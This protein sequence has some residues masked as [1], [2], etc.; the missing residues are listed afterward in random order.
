MPVCCCLSC[1][2]RPTQ[3]ACVASV[4]AGSCCVLPHD[5]LSAPTVTVRHPASTL[6]VPTAA[7]HCAGSHLS[8]PA[9]GALQECARL[10]AAPPPACK[11][12]SACKPA[13]AALQ[14]VPYKIVR[15]D[16][17]DAWV[18]AGGNRYSPSQVR[19]AAGAR[20]GR[21]P[22]RVG[23]EAW[24][25][26]WV[27]AQPGCVFGGAR[28]RFLNRKPLLDTTQCS[29]TTFL[30]LP[31]HPQMGAFVLMKMKETAERYLGRPVSQVGARIHVAAHCM[32]PQTGGSS[33]RR[34]Q[35]ARRRRQA[36]APGV[37]VSHLDTLH[38][39]MR[40]PDRSHGAHLASL[41]SPFLPR[42]LLSPCLPTSTTTNARQPRWAL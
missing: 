5:L 14:M 33:R 31:C 22:C 32:V 29:K 15:A 25:G 8:L 4:P 11:P 41:P 26:V 16:N 39:R 9:D 27:R 28:G 21:G 37:W 40:M 38:C 35:Q 1:R 24:S 42:R 34:R 6:P 10:S 18:E 20:A 36:A 19:A 7:C 12:C 13:S 2:R 3:A 30:P 17:G 23:E